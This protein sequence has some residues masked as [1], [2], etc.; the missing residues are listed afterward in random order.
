[1]GRPSTTSSGPP[2][3]RSGSGSCTSTTR[4]RSASANR[5]GPGTATSSP[6]TPEGSTP[7]GDRVLQGDPVGAV[8]GADGDRVLVGGERPGAQLAEV[9]VARGLEAVRQEPVGEL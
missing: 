7:H 5:P 4:R 2:A 3:T 1:C 9:G 6:R 8:H